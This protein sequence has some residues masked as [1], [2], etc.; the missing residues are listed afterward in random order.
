MSY[1]KQHVYISLSL[2]IY[3]Y[4]CVCIH[5]YIYIYIHITYPCGLSRSKGGRSEGLASIIAVIVNTD[6]Y[7]C[8]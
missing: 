5:T 1:H 8:S 6:S 7:L 2:Y 3:I 4:M